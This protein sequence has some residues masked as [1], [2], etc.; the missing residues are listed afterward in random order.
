MDLD[1]AFVAALVREGKAGLKKAAEAGVSS[2]SLD[3]DCAAAYDFLLDYT[4]TYGD[5]PKL[6]IVGSKFSMPDLD[7]HDQGAPVV[8]LAGELRNRRLLS[9]LRDGLD[10]VTQLVQAQQGA[11]ALDSLEDLILEVRKQ[12]VVTSAQVRGLFS[13]GPEVVA[14]Y[15]RIKAGERG[16]LTPWPTLNDATL[17]FWP[18]DLVLFVARSGVGKTWMSVLVADCAWRAKKKVLYV[19][20]EMSQIRIAMRF[21]AIQLRLPYDPYRKG[22]LPMFVEE[23]FFKYAEDMKNDPLIQVMGGNFDFRVESVARAIDEVKPDLVVIDGIY[24]LKV[25]GQNRTEQAANAFNEVKRLNKLKQV[26]ILVTS[27][28]N[29]QSKQGNESTVKAEHIALTDVAVWNAD[30]IF[31]MVQDDDGKKTGRMKMV[32]LKVREGVS[33]DIEVNWNFETMLFDE[34]PKGVPGASSVSDAYV[35]PFG[36]GGPGGPASSGEDPGVPF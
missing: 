10:P 17:G 4:S 29:R 31:G 11:K 34:L 32:P 21:Y 24:L 20:T 36:G 16:V 1:K 26:P 28:L 18:E 7:F 25:A 3:G 9:T 19:T 14:Y 12:S 5:L 27:Q 33:E 8:F 13:L 6:E 35:D 2:E 30:L 22:Q 15:K 23:K